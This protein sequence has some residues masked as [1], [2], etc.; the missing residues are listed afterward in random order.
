MKPHF[1]SYLLYTISRPN[2]YGK[3]LQDLSNVELSSTSHVLIDKVIKK[4]FLHVDFLITEKLRATFKSKLWRMGRA[5]ARGG[6]NQRAKLLEKWKEG[7]ESVWQVE[8]DGIEYN[9]KLVG[10]TRKAEVRLSVEQQKRAKL[11]AEL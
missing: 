5:L 7:D 2:K 4:T 6:G 11:E 3:P 9:K 10:M 8:I 1:Y